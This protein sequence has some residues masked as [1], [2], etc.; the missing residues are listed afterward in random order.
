MATLRPERHYYENVVVTAPIHR[1]ILVS[2]P[3]HEKIISVVC[4]ETTNP[5]EVIEKNEL[6]ANIGIVP[7]N[8]ETFWE[9]TVEGRR[10]RSI[11][12]E[13]DGS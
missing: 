12:D 9:I 10:R 5:P 3:L 8:C 2:A 7:Y 11:D 6:H 1:K 4:D 13:W